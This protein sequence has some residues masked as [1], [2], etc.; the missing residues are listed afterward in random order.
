MS[1]V[2]LSFFAVCFFC[3][4]IASGDNDLL[5]T[6]GHGGS[7]AGI[8]LVSSKGRDIRSFL[9]IPYAKPPVGSLRFESPVPF[10][11]WEGTRN[12]TADGSNCPQTFPLS[13]NQKVEGNEDCLFVNV[14]TPPVTRIPKAGLAVMV[15]IH[16]GAWIGGSNHHLMYGPHYLLDQD[17]VLVAINYRVGPLGFMSTETLDCP[18]NYGL[19]DQVEA[20]RWVRQHISS[21][22]GNPDSVTIFGESAGGAS[23]SYLLQSDKPRGLFHRAIPQSGTIFGSW[24]QPLHKGVA[25]SRAVKMAEFFNCDNEEKDWKKMVSCLMLSR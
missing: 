9:G 14:Y 5:V 19:K 13:P 11:S 24:S 4:V 16:G 8:N 18:G 6:L 12:A 20:L 2:F 15:W 10:P 3:G 25:Q 23:V 21:F 1:R 22:G 7:L 17:I